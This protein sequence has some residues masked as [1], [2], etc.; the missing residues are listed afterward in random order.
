[1]INTMQQYMCI[2]CLSFGLVW[3]ELVSFN[4]TWSQKGHSVSCM[5]I[6]F[7]K[8]VQISR[9]DIKPH[10]KWAVSLVILHMVTS[11]FLRA[12]CGYIWVNMLALSPRGA[13]YLL[14]C[15]YAPSVS[16]LYPCFHYLHMPPS[17]PL[18]SPPFGVIF[19]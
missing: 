8:Q 12:L 16:L 14:T 6:L 18:P 10:I 4:D 7:Y 13:V 5:T 2:I 3:F 17:P 11:I 15:T 19:F 9:S 1:M